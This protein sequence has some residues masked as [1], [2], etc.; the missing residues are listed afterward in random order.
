MVRSAV[1]RDLA[2]SGICEE[3]LLVDGAAAADY[4]MDGEVH[5]FGEED[6]ADGWY[7]V[8]EVTFEILTI[9]P[10]GRTSEVAVKL[11][12]RI[13]GEERCATQTPAAVVEALGRALA[14]VDEELKTALVEALAED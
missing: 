1:E 10:R 6:R 5:R 11:H 9:E 8:V 14:R 7:A 2:L 12:R 4:V 13:R 3:V